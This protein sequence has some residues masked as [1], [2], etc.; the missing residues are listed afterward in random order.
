VKDELGRVIASTYDKADRLTKV[1]R[2]GF[3]NRDGTTR[4]IV[5]E[6]R[7]HDAAGR[8]VRTLSGNGTRRVDAAYD[9]AGRMTSSTLD[10]LGLNRTTAWVRDGAGNVLTETLSDGTRTEETR[11]AYDDGGR[12]VS[13]TIENGTVDVVTTYGYDQRGNLAWTVDPRGNT[14]GSP[15]QAFKTTLEHDA[16]SRPVRRTAPSVV[17]EEGGSATTAQPFSVIGYNTFGD[18]V[19]TVDERGKTTVTDVDRLG[20]RTGVTHPSYV[21]PAPTGAAAITPTEAFSYDRVGNLRWRYDRRGQRTDFAFDKRN[22]VV[23][24]LDPSVAGGARG[25]TRFTY[26]DAGNRMAT[27]DP[28]GARTEWTYDKLNRQ[29]TE[30]AVVRRE[31]QTAARYTTTFDYDDLGRPSYLQDAA[32]AVSTQQWSPAGELLSATDALLKTTTH[33]YDVAGR[34][35]KTTDPLGRSSVVATDLAGRVTAASRVAPNGSVMTT[36]G[37]GHDLAGN[38]TSI[39]SARG[40]TTTF[41]VD[42]DGRLTG[43]T[44]PV[45]AGHAID[46][47]YGYDAAGNLTR[48]TDGRGNVTLRTYNAWNLPQSTV[49]PSTAAHPSLADRSWT[50]GFAQG[51]AD[52]L[53][54]G[55]KAPTTDIRVSS[56]GAITFEDGG[57]W[58]WFHPASVP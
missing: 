4:D 58:R 44:Q 15:D 57:E 43:V 5:I 25:E 50:G 42:A 40:F 13:E 6:E 36:T 55:V 27:V 7:V 54:V 10:P 24:Q 53:G 16:L 12:K 17:V 3:E 14:D 39:T 34:R 33:E 30:T 20:R 56:R 45:D 2:I 41:A 48:F 35:V 52:E 37:F 23:Q 28:T 19:A 21:P 38:R 51:L 49:D 1:T 31:G 47:G 9:A 26:D 8:I 18:A 46:V 32:G 22:R 11:T 29:R